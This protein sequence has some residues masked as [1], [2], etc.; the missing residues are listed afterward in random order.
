MPG[1]GLNVDLHSDF[2]RA[3]TAAFCFLVRRA[4]GRVRG[5]DHLGH[6]AAAE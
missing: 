2:R 4:C 6:L 3:A 1:F 5:C